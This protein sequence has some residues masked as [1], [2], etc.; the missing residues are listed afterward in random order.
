[1]TGWQGGK[2]RVLCLDNTSKCINIPNLPVHMYFRI[3]ILIDSSSIIY[4]LQ[5]Q[6]AYVSVWTHFQL[7]KFIILIT[8]WGLPRI[9]YPSG[10]SS[11]EIPQ[12]EIITF[13]WKLI[14]I[15]NLKSK[16]ATAYIGKNVSTIC[17]L[18]FQRNT[19]IFIELFSD[20]R[21][22][23]FRVFSKILHAYFTSHWDW[24]AFV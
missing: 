23:F 10:N 15:L 17:Q 1:M 14:S 21:N 7:S 20:F 5:W 6:N 24:L 11:H 13:C 16:P 18:D 2:K 9:F 22:Y 3:D 4:Y 12:T 19:F 8:C